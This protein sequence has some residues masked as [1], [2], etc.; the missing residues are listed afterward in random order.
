MKKTPLI[1]SVIAIVAVIV[2]VVL[3][4]TTGNCKRAEESNS[5]DVSKTTVKGNIVY[6]NMDRILKE[7]DMA[8]ELRS[9]VESKIQ[10]INQE[11]TRRGNKLQGQVNEFQEKID[12]GL[13]TRSVAEIQGQKLQQQQNEFNTFAAK[14]QQEISEEQ[15]VMMNRIGDAIKKFIDKF[16]K[17]KKYSLIIATQG[18]I[19]P[20]PVVSA[21]TTLDITNEIL[22]GLNEE[23]VKTK[24]KE[25]K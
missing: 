4:F 15:T 10:G 14:K 9:A 19:L 24:A 6:F 16:N 11:V 20:A 22:E 7:Y 3:Q 1:L 23:Y 25:G 17:T 5:G 21:D 8:N 13:I 12:K 18:D 2:M